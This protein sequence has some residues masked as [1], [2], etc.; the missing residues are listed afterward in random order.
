M[1][2]S[3]AETACIWTWLQGAG[4]D[5]QE[6]LQDKD[7]AFE[8]VTAL[9]DDT[10]EQADAALETAKKAL[11]E[12]DNAAISHVSIALHCTAHFMSF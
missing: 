4:L 8:A 7:E 10:L 6:A 11:K 2:T 3:F 1:H 5:L 9:L 12:A